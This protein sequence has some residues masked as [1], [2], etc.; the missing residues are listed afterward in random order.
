[1][2]FRLLIII[3]PSI[4]TFSVGCSEDDKSCPDDS[5]VLCDLHCTDLKTDSDHCG[6]CD[7]ACRED[8]TCYEGTC[9]CPYGYTGRAIGVRHR[10]LTHSMP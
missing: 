2:R 6:E 3:L 7:N 9:M 10:H 4:I 8:E 1:M 5:Y